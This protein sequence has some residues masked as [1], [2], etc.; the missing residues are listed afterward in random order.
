MEPLSSRIESLLFVS[1][2]P[3]TVV[4]IKRALGDGVTEEEIALCIKALQKEYAHRGVHILEKDG[5][6]QMV[7]APHNAPLIGSF[8]KSQ[9]AE[10]LTPA[11]LETL[12]CIAYKEPISKV[13][14]DELRGGNSI[15]SL[16]SLLMRGLIEKTKTKGKEGDEHAPPLQSEGI[17]SD[18]SA[19]RAGHAVVY[20][21][22]TL[23]FLKKLGIEKVNELPQYDELSQHS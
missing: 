15:F 6:V 2:D 4:K 20:Y 12:A 7:S 9:L 19:A 22:T 17:S 11:A 21:R 5:A 1:G 3:L 13:Q 14:I 23:D 8:V 18:G 10:E 16:R